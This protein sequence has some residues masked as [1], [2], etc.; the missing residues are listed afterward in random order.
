MQRNNNKIHNKVHWRRIKN[1]FNSLVEV[2][3]VNQNQYNFSN[4]CCYACMGIELQGINVKY[5]TT[6]RNGLLGR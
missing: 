3:N 1:I 2:E 5:K 6:G 4:I